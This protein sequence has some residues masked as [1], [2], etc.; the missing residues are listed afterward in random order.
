MHRIFFIKKKKK[1]GGAWKKFAKEDIKIIT[2]VIIIKHEVCTTA[3]RCIPNILDVIYGPR[4]Y[5]NVLRHLIN[6]GDHH[7]GIMK[8][9]WLP[10]YYIG[11]QQCIF[12]PHV[13]FLCTG[14]LK[15]LISVRKLH[16]LPFILCYEFNSY[17]YMSNH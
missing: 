5:K 6:N 14:T 9:T 7:G 17:Q 11:C 1:G 13:N 12:Q 2:E 3:A 15:C 8:K 10:V 4:Q 16:A